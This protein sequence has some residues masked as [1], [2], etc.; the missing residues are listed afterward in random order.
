MPSDNNA[1]GGVVL[2]DVGGVLILWKDEWAFKVL[3]RRF[4]V[5]YS[6]VESTILPLR[7]GLHLGK[8][9]LHQFWAK[10]ANSVG[11]DL[12]SDWR[13]LWGDELTKRAK[14]NAS[15]LRIA[16]SLRRSGVRTGIFSNT[17]ASHKEIFRR[18]RWFPGLEPWVLSFELGAVKPNPLAFQR[19][20]TAL[21]LDAHDIL[22]I[23][24]REA[25]VRAARSCG[26]EA[27]LYR[28]SLELAR[29]LRRKGLL[30]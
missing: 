15:A 1:P 26:W 22:L 21:G 2:F 3:S 30:G 4:G 9:D 24:D 28:S 25:N 5:P 8:L 13:T 11:A 12:P 10:F 7:E 29:T 18:L 16:T 6:L 27:T 17:D 20:T 14:V 19:A 23:D